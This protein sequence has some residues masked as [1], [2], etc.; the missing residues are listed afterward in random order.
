LTTP[1][2]RRL[3]YAAATLALVQPLVSGAGAQRFLQV[4]GFDF[5]VVLLLAVALWLAGFQSKDVP[6]RR[7]I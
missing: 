1:L 5:A 6:I 4:L 2:V 3:I 7:K